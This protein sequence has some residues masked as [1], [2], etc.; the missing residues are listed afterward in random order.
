MPPLSRR[1]FGLQLAATAIAAAALPARAAETTTF[2]LGCITANDAAKY[3]QFAQ[4]LG[5][6][7]DLAVLYFN[8]SAPDALWSSVPWICNLAAGF[9]RQ[10]AQVLWSVP[11]PGFR[12][13]EAIVAGHWDSQYRNLFKSILAAS[14]SGSADIPVRLPWEFNLAQQENAAFDKTGKFDAALFVQSFRHLADLAKKVSPRFRRIWCTNACTNGLDPALCWP[15]ADFVEVIAQDFYL[16]TAWN[17]P[18]AF[19]WF[20][21]EARGLNWGRDF[22]AQQNRPYGL[23]EWGMDSDAFLADFKDACAWL[24]ALGQ[25]LDHHCWWD[26]PEVTDCRISDGTNPALAAEYRRQWG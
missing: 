7:P 18:G 25:T 24:K 4:Y 5:R 15:G 1:D 13:H 9:I 16:Q 3:G 22:A 21:T 6:K 2:K 26:R 17:K 14:P 23:S 11:C 20:L 10:G 19:N 12:Q 8:Q